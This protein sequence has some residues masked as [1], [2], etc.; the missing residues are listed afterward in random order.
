METY[1]LPQ[2]CDE[3]NLQ[4]NVRRFSKRQHVQKAGESTR[5]LQWTPT[6]FAAFASL[7]E[8]PNS[9]ARVRLHPSTFVEFDI[10]VTGYDV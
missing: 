1:V 5:R 7:S 6:P 9:C 10:T 2:V 4:P 8:D 3:V